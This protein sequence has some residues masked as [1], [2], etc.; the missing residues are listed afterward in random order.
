MSF[1]TAVTGLF[2]CLEI[3]IHV[4]TGHWSSGG[5]GAGVVGHGAHVGGGG[6]GV[7]GLTY[8]TENHLYYECTHFSKTY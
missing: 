2:I 3:G 8:S 5:G 1:R 7:L 6:G 4:Q